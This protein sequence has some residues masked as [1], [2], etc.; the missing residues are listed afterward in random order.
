MTPVEN[1]SWNSYEKLVLNE[2]QTLVEGQK[3]MNTRLSTLELAKAT[4]EA[5]H[6]NEAAWQARI[7]SA[8]AFVL[9]IVINRVW[10]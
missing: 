3:E 7:Y 2:L 9:G 10:K 8:I 5:N 6:K 1:N 4:Y